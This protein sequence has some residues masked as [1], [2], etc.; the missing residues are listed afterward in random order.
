[1]PPFSFCCCPGCPIF[2]CVVGDACLGSVGAADEVAR[3]VRESEALGVDRVSAS[4]LDTVS[5]PGYFLSR[6]ETFWSE[7]Q[8]VWSMAFH[9]CVF[10][11]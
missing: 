6:Y 3:V 8:S 1:V 10:N 4:A 7:E 9:S 5:S 11:G 2:G